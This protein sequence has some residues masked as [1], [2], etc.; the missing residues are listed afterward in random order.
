[1][2]AIGKVERTMYS[3]GRGWLREKVPADLAMLHLQ[4]GELLGRDARQLGVGIV[5]GSHSA[6]KCDTKRMYPELSANLWLRRNFR[7]SDPFSF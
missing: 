3:S 5:Q 6:E 7:G 4:D 2:H 1:M